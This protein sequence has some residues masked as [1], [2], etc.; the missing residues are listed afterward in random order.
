M[1]TFEPNVV[2]SS[3][4]SIVAYVY[5]GRPTLRFVEILFYFRPHSSRIENHFRQS[6]FASCAFVISA[7]HIIQCTLRVMHGWSEMMACANKRHSKAE[8]KWAM[9]NGLEGHWPQQ[10]NHT[11]RQNA[12]FAVKCI[13]YMPTGVVVDTIAGVAGQSKRWWFH[14]PTII[15]S[16]SISI[17]SLIAPP[18][19]DNSAHVHRKLREN[20]AETFIHKYGS[21]VRILFARYDCVDWRETV[22]SPRKFI[23]KFRATCAR[24]VHSTIHF[25]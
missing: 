10:L 8:T 21:S 11:R 13:A 18:H 22:H 20:T 3:N 2:H 14:C 9:G 25:R 6:V 16:F 12:L 7:L 1:R 5:R 19:Y 4:V 23:S 17:Y 24:G 15:L